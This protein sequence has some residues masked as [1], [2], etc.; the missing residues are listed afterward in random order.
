[1]ISTH[2]AVIDSSF[3]F[4]IGSDMVAEQKCVGEQKSGSLEN[5]RLRRK[6][7]RAIFA[8][9]GDSAR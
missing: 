7:V 2:G 6:K 8:S 1:M 4:R 9:Q 5:R 3:L